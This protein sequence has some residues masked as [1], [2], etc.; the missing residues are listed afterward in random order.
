MILLVFAIII[1]NKGISQSYFNTISPLKSFA[2]VT[3]FDSF[4]FGTVYKIA[5]ELVKED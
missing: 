1:A 5:L 4:F 3:H 2:T